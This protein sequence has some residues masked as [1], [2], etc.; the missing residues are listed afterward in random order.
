MRHRVTSEKLSRSRAQKK[1]LVKS[2]VRAVIINERITTTT[3]K[4]KYLRGEVDKMITWGKKGTLSCKRLAYRILEDHKLVQ[5]LFETIAPRFK[6]INGGYTRVL[7]VKPRLGD[8]AS[9]SLIELTRRQEKI[10]KLKTP[11]EQAKA[12]KEEKT[13]IKEG[14]IV[15]PKKEEKPKKGIFSGLKTSFKKRDSI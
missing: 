4:A 14:K 8:G 10:K 9:L 12:L 2:L 7:K 13:T 3:S 5:K 15:P 6:E 1:A 11:K